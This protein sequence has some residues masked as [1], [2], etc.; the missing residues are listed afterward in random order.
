MK[1]AILSAFLASTLLAGPVLA[2]TTTEPAPAVTPA[3][4]ATTTPAAP[5]AS[6]A[7]PAAGASDMMI[8][9]PEGYVMTEM[10]SVTA[11]E[12]KGVDIY[13]PAGNKIAEIADVEI[14]PDNKVTGVITDVGG[15]L[16]MGE[17][18]VSLA[19]DQIA[20]YK[21]SDNAMRAYVS[22]SKDEMKALP[23]YME[24]NQ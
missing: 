4:E 21:N 19:P 20:V 22:M 6:D 2:Q 10:M 7:A 14:G 16:G 9:A 3:P 24:P 18:R 5:M 13:D 11:D 8:V 23:A 15:F 12:L 17:H 1:H